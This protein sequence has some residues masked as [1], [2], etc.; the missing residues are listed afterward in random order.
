[1]RRKPA[2]AGLFYPA[3]RQAL[4]NWLEKVME[5]TPGKIYN[6]RGVMVPHAGYVYSGRVASAVYSSTHTPDIAIIMGPNHTGLGPKASIMTRGYW[7]T[8]LGSVRIEETLAEAILKSSSVLQEDELAHLREHSVEVQVPFLQYQNP[9]IKIIPIVFFPLSY[10]E[11]ED[12]ATAIAET[13]KTA[14]ERVLIVASTDMSHYLPSYI[15]KEKDELALREVLSLN[16]RGLIG[17]VIKHDISMCGYIPT[18]VMLEASKILGASRAELIAYSHS[19][20]VSGEEPVVGYAGV[21]I[22]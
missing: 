9:G 7:E 3:D 12:V 19:G 4:W 22:Y 16:P 10:E 15:A 1:M 14:E 21:V 18:A 5:V 6:A 8:P 11:I 20:E 17:T 2:V 13:I